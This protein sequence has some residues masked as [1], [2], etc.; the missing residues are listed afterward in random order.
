MFVINTNNN[1]ARPEQQQKKVN[2]DLVNEKIRF[3]EVLVISSDGKQLGVK[4]RN[5]ALRLAQDENL[6][7]L[8]VAPA[9]KPPVCKILN[10]GKHRFEQQ[11]K[12]REMK[13]NQKVIEVKEV[14]L[15]PQTDTHDL[16]TK[17]RA[18]AKWVKDGNKIKVTVKYRGRQMSHIEIGEETLNEFIEMCSE[19]T[20]VEKKP[21]MDGRLLI[22]NL[23]PKPASK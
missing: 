13:K 1:Y 7:L 2:E 19:F 12:A 22:C 21:Q 4:T 10:Y 3:P 20:I 6:D 15:T 14:R 18:V 23:A 17:A 8:C 9:A 11:K 16:E 5:E